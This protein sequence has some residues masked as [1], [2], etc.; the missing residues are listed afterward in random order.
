MRNKIIL[1]FILSLF[2]LFGNNTN[3]YGWTC[4][5][6]ASD[7]SSTCPGGGGSCTI[8][9]HSCCDS[10]TATYCNSVSQCSVSTPVCP[11]G[12]STS[13]S[14]GNCSSCTVTC[15][16]CS[17][18]VTCYKDNPT[19]TACNTTCPSNKYH[20]TECPNGWTESGCSA[21]SQPSGCT[22]TYTCCDCIPPA[23]ACRSASDCGSDSCLRYTCNNAGTTSAY[24]SSVDNGTCN[25]EVSDS[26][27]FVSDPCYVKIN[28]EC[29]PQETTVNFI[30]GSIQPYNCSCKKAYQK[31]WGC[32]PDYPY[33]CYSPQGVK[34][35]YDTEVCSYCGGTATCQFPTCTDGCVSDGVHPWQLTLNCG[36]DDCDDANYWATNAYYIF[37]RSDYGDYMCLNQVDG[38]GYCYEDE[39]CNYCNGPCVTDACPT[40]CHTGTLVRNGADVNGFCSQ[41]WCNPT[42]PVNGVCGGSNGGTFLTAPTVNLCS[43]GTPSLVTTSGYT[44]SWTCSGNCTGAAA[45][46]TAFAN[47]PPTFQGL[48]IKNKTNIK[49]SAESGNK[50]QICDTAFNGERLVTFEVSVGDRDGITDIANGGNVTLTWNGIGITRISAIGATTIFGWS[51]N[52]IIPDTFN[53]SSTY[54]L[55]VTITDKQNQSVANATRYFKFWDCKVPIS[56][57]FYDGTDGSNCGTGEGF[58]T[59]ADSTVLNLKSLVFTGG[60]I[61]VNMETINSP[62]Y[63]SG[64][65]YLTWG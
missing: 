40:E 2:F 65:N 19:T 9:N 23:I 17:N 39:M 43:A 5:K 8:T 38:K 29:Y 49:V 36:R 14:S 35:C 41:R 7:I 27:T 48:V 64:T 45:N 22:D 42:S 21:I 16:G 61:G 3:V 46:C 31:D 1:C 34:S 25:E 26:C 20:K 18:S 52:N 58:V 32:W 50:N 12:Y 28:G 60:G 37:C 62:N 6:S 11:S 44:Y 4:C 59:P 15:T 10:N 53:S 30:G 56:G 51:G 24:C 13:C 63:S 54:S 47:S 33:A 55:S 57:T